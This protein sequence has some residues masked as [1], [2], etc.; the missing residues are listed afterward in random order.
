MSPS[1]SFSG[2][3]IPWTTIE[4]GERQVAA[5]ISLVA[6]ERRHAAV[7][8]D[9]L[10]GDV[11][12]LGRGD[13]G[14]QLLLE[15]R[16]R[17]GHDLPGPRHRLDLLGRLA[18]DHATTC[19]E[20]EISDHTS[21]IVRSACNGHELAG[22]AV[23]LDDRLGLGVVDREPL[24]DQ[25]GRVVGAALQLRALERS[26]HADLV[27]HVEEQD[28]V[29]APADPAEHRV[30]RL[31][32]REVAREAVEHEPAL[33]VRLREAL[34]DHRDRQFVGHEPAGGHDLA[35]LLAELGALGL[36]GAEH[37]TRRDVRN[38]VLRSDALGLR[39]L[40]GPLRAEDEEIHRRKPS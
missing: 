19:S 36:R 20:S 17:L 30:Q 4:F 2:P 5:G 7:R 29:Q 22:G 26:L 16:E 24:R 1:W 10:V 12:E 11:V 40:A 38:P 34:L 31:G 35:D 14:L 27:G 21:S 25:L 3:G 9:E 28:R 23:V 13:A 32:L 6:L 8:A 33:G 15:E 18:D 39:A 37:V